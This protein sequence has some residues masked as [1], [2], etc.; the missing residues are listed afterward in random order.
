MPVLSDALKGAGKALPKLAKHLPKLWPL[1]LESRNREKI[2]EL[3]RE[4][5]SSSPSR[6]L[7]AKMELTGALAETMADQAETDAE[8]ERAR[9]W[10]SR[11]AKMRIRLDMPIEGV[12]AK[13]EHRAQ[14]RA[15]LQ[16]LHAEM[17]DALRDA[18]G[19]SPPR[20]DRP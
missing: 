9:E 15:D 1:L 13:R 12:R 16:A 18:P 5:A 8:R 19:G 6:K 20:L 3:S 17:S 14:L 2:I 4:L 7:A 11:A 10:Q